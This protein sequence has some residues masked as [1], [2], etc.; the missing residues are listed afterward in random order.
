MGHLSWANKKG[1]RDL[2]DAGAITLPKREAVLY[3]YTPVHR[4]RR[5]ATLPIVRIAPMLHSKRTFARVA[6]TCRPICGQMDSIRGMLVRRPVHGMQGALGTARSNELET[7]Y[8]K[9]RA[10]WYDGLSVQHALGQ[11]EQEQAPWQR[12][13]RG[14]AAGNAASGPAHARTP[15]MLS[16]P[17]CQAAQKRTPFGFVVEIYLGGVYCSR[18]PHFLHCVR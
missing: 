9:P 13:R 14:S 6:R 3:F 2:L 4:P 7:P 15:C 1:D 16:E 10:V 11:I 8:P 12:V 17:E 18:A 5:H